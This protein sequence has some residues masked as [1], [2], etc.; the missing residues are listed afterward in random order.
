MIPK[1]AST[2]AAAAAA[3]VRLLL[4]SPVL[5]CMHLPSCF[6][7]SRSM[8]GAAQRFHELRV[9]YEVL[10]RPITRSFYDAQA[11]GAR[12]A[13]EMGN[14]AAAA[15]G[16][17]TEEQRMLRR[18]RYRRY[19]TQQRNDVPY[20]DLPGAVSLQGFRVYGSAA[21]STRG[22]GS[23]VSHDEVTPRDVR[24]DVLVKAF[25]NPL[26]GQWERL[27]QGYIPPQPHQLHRQYRARQPSLRLDRNHMPTQFSMAQMP[28]SQTQPALLVMDPLTGEHIWTA[29]L[30]KR[31]SSSSS[32][33]SSNKSSTSNS[34]KDVDST[35]NSRQP[36]DVAATRA[37]E[38]PAAEQQLP[39][40]KPHGV[41]ALCS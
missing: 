25:F 39:P 11:D 3:A 36:S 32:N 23:R 7:A 30:A 19:A 16:E 41:A 6:S 28:L 14:A 24:G 8:H 38:V 22:T 27:P 37:A 10:S 31:R 29:D 2:S 33:S 13:S 5:P 15:W 35:R 34:S 12:G 4:L 17:E 21:E 9:A 26:S 1:S 18:E 20:D 40:P